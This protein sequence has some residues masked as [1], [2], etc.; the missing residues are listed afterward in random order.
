MENNNI[1]TTVL[2]DD[3]RPADY[4]RPLGRFRYIFMVSL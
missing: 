4:A 2:A 3:A 1:I